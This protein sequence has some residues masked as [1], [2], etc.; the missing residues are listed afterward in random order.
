MFI[1][2]VQIMDYLSAV[3][4]LTEF[5]IYTIINSFYRIKGR[6]LP[7]GEP[8]K[9]NP[10][11][12]ILILIIND[13]FALIL[14]L[15]VPFLILLNIYYPLLNWSTF[16]ILIPLKY[17]PLY[18]QIIGM[19]I[20]TIGVIMINLALFVIKERYAPLWEAP[21]LGEGF[22]HT[23]IYSRIRHPIYGS[24]IL[25]SIGYVIWFQSWLAT[26]CLITLPIIF[27]YVKEEEKWLLKR[28]GKEY[29]DYMKKTWRFFPKLF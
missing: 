14:W 13:I 8:I 22:A 28:F 23:G 26:L 11:V 17:D 20:F 12:H 2:I 1:M 29:E 10:F 4:L 6:K 16:N 18:F 7:R 15:T 3:V 21:K 5:I 25:I 19:V 9:L 27:K 24:L